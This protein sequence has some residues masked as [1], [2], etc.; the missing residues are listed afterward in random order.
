MLLHGF[1]FMAGTGIL[2]WPAL[3]AGLGRVP[4]SRAYRTL[5]LPCMSIV[6]LAIQGTPFLSIPKGTWIRPMGWAGLTMLAAFLLMI[7]SLSKSIAALR[8]YPSKTV[9]VVAILFSLVILVT[10]SYALHTIAYI[11]GLHLS[12]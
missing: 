4:E 8:R 1:S 6:W 3:R 9:P 11:K 10:P 2:G 12:P 7:F 5:V